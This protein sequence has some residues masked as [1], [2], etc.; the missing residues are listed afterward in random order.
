MEFSWDEAKQLGHNYIGTEHLLLGLIRE[1]EG[2]AVKVLK[3]LGV[4]IDDLKQQVLTYIKT[5]SGRSSIDLNYGDI[6]TTNNEPTYDFKYDDVK[7]LFFKV[8]KLKEL[9]IRNSDFLKA[10]YYREIQCIIADFQDKNI[11]EIRELIKKSG[12]T[13]S[14]FINSSDSG[15]YV[16]DT[17][18]LSVSNNYLEDSYSS[19]LMNFIR[20]VVLVIIFLL[21]CRY[22]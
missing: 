19:G 11:D 12:I 9:S 15:D 21:Y 13:N 18:N 2:V 14:S 22:H 4:D 8:Q 5:Q 3:N 6:Q 10:S 7:D 17:K 1:G 16:H 20:I